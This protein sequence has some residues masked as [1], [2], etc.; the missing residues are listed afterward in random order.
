MIGQHM[1]LIDEVNL[2]ATSTW[3]VLHIVEKLSRVF[4]LG[5]R[6]R[7]NFQEVDE[8]SLSDLCARAALLAG[9]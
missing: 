9:N 5:T 1:H 4:D 8:T 2:E 3:R 6:R 7:V